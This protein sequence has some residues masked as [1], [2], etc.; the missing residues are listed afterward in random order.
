MSSA[1]SNR[2]SG[3]SSGHYRSS[4]SSGS[5]SSCNCNFYIDLID[6]GD[7]NGGIPPANLGQF[8]VVN[9]GTCPVVITSYVAANDGFVAFP[10]LPYTLDP[11]NDVTFSIGGYDEKR[12]TDFHLVTSC[13]DSAIYTYPERPD[14]PL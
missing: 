1:S 8:R 11:A 9:I 2:S 4:S 3:A 10:P 13:G 7:D 12:S 6:V 14:Y 5:S